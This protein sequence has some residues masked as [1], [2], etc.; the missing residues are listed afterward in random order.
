MVFHVRS[1]FLGRSLFENVTVLAALVLIVLPMKA[2]GQSDWDLSEY[3][4]WTVTSVK[5]EGLS[6]DITSEI[7][8][9]LA[10]ARREGLLGTKHP[11]FFPEILKQDMQ[12]TRLF[13]AV[14]G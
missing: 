6:D 5:V 4:D 2:S 13:L 9:G 12:R 8:T 1:L 14:R 7:R 3:K 11:V 10:L